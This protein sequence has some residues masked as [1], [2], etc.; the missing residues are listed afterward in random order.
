MKKYFCSGVR[1]HTVVQN[2]IKKNVGDI[3]ETALEE[4]AVVSKNESYR[5][6][7]VPPP[8]C[9]NC[10]KVGH[11]SNKCFVKNAKSK[12][13]GQDIKVVVSSVI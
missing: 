7:V 11:S 3:T 9:K 8:K 12:C 6:D 5:G 1:I 13:K 4:S 10:A 2:C